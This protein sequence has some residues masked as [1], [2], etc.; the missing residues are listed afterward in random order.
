[1]S[2]ALHECAIAFVPLG[3]EV[4]REDYDGA[5]SDILS[6]W[7]MVAMGDPVVILFSAA[8]LAAG[9]GDATKR[10]EICDDM[11]VCKELRDVSYGHLLWCA[12]LR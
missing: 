7:P 1:M 11:R 3:Y 9:K 2:H 10:L 8:L 4:L 12:F 6:P 5:P